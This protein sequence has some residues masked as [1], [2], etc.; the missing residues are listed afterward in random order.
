MLQPCFTFN[1][2]QTFNFYLKNTYNLQ[3]DATY[4]AQHRETALMRSFEHEKIPIGLFY[5][6]TG[7]AP[8]HQTLS[9]LQT[10]LVQQSIAETDIAQ[11]TAAFA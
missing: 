6:Q 4:N 7:V 9:Q 3:Q 11:V 10:P 5:Q 2:D 8:F 1:H